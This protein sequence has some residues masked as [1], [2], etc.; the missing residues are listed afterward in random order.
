VL[1]NNKYMENKGLRYNEGKLPYNLIP[2]S[3]TREI[4]KG[5]LYGKNKYSIKDNDGN[6][7]SDGSNN[8]KK[9][10]KASE[11]IGSL[12]RHIEAYKN[13]EDFDPES[14]LYHLALAACNIG[15]LIDGYENSNFIDDRE[16]KYLSNKKIGLDIDGVLADFSASFI[17]LAKKEGINTN[18]SFDQSHWNFP[19]EY[20]VLWNKIKNDK[21]FWLNIK[22]ITTNL[23]FEPDFYVTSRS[24]PSSWTEE[25]ISKNNL[26][27]V[28][29]YTTNGKSKVDILKQLKCDTFLDDCFS[30]FKEL[31]Q[32]GIRTFLMNQTYNIKHD[33]GYKRIYNVNSLYSKI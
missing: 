28:P 18:N 6:I 26:P 27:C 10:L 24:I 29:V 13:G 33:V 4:S 8:W 12:L 30:N 23:T 22:P 2:S 32:S 15:F 11:T 5:L 16:H 1:L 3:L 17:E 25:W 9:G 19:Y 7:I 20:N 21:E 14:G 31:N